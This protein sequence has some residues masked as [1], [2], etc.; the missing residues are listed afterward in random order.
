[1]KYKDLEIWKAAHGLAIEIHLLTLK[2]LP[3]FEKFETGSQIRRS[4]K[5]V[6]ANIVEGYGRR[7][8]KQDFI[9][10][11]I[12][13]ESS[14]DE[15]IEHLEILHESGSMMNKR[16]Y[17]NLHQRLEILGKMLNVFISRVSVIHQPSSSIPYDQG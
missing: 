12:Y 11:L 2:D 14:V 4:M 8:Y 3:A 17:E 7:R 10:F 6:S 9:R 1:M 5:S 13:A 16:K 15:T